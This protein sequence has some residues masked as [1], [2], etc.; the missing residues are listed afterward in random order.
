MMMRG[1]ADNDEA[2]DGSR[3][4][5]WLRLLMPKRRAWGEG[6]GA[7]EISRWYCWCWVDGCRVVALSCVVPSHLLFLEKGGVNNF[8]KIYGG[9]KSFL[10]TT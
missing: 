4:R 6:H 10:T 3:S 1:E 5:L 8:T 2:G 7:K 9:K